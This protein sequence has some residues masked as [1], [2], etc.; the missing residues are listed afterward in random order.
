MI[1]RTH[2]HVDIAAHYEYLVKRSAPV[3]ERFLAAVREGFAQLRGNP[4]LGMKL[5]M[6][7][8]EHWDLRFYRVR[9]FGNYLII[10]RVIDREL[11][12]LRLLH[13]SQDWEC[14]IRDTFESKS[15]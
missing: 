9:S 1:L 14:A 3:A 11:Y 15:P 10:V 4:T 7:E 5:H 8:R 6:P 13:G 2:V 12:V